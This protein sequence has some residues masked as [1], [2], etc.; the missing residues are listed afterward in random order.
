MRRHPQSVRVFADRVSERCGA[1]MAAF[2]VRLFR[3]WS[4]IMRHANHG[5]HRNRE[6]EN[7][8]SRPGELKTEK[9]K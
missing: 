5:A 9:E 4:Q 2:S 3:P 6:E 1:W 8:G 7:V